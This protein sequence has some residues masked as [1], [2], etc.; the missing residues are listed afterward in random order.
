MVGTS[1]LLLALAVWA[2]FFR[3]SAAPEQTPGKNFGT[4]DTRSSVGVGS[5]PFG[6]S[7]NQPLTATDLSKKIFRIHPGPVAGAAFIQ[8]FNPTTTVARFVLAENGHV[9]DLVV[10]SPGAIA[11]PVSNTTIPGI[12]ETVWTQ[13]G[14]GV[15]LRY[16]DRE[17]KKTV[18]LGFSTSTLATTT[19]LSGS[20]RIQFLP[21]EVQSIAASPDGASL[22]YLLKTDAGT[23]GYVARPDGG[24]ARKLF[25]LPLSQLLV[26]WPS[27]GTILAYTPAASGVAGILFSVDARTGGT[28]P[29]LRANGL[30]ASADRAFSRVVYQ[31][32]DAAGHPTYSHNNKTGLDTALSFDPLPEECVWSALATSTAYCPAPMSYVPGGFIDQW[33]K[34]LGS[35]AMGVFSYDYTNRSTFVAVPGS[36]D[37]GVASDIVA[38]QLSPD[39]KYL[40]FVKK[41]ERSL[42]GVRLTQN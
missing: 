32:A 31:T 41:G 30:T 1:I 21:N 12:A 23:D 13:K 33:H 8:T 7:G 16:L 36:P 15:V 20:V 39:E 34:G 25:S 4:S 6:A 2:L 37:G 19:S 29:L 38:L 22:V 42:W 40:L 9:M 35:V 3:T 28:A 10:D 26:S 14:A 24:N 17:V 27:V 5:T 18:T 11:R